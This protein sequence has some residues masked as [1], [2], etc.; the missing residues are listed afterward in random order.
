VSL[1]NKLEALEREGAPIRV[2][3]VGAGQMGRGFIAQVT[4]IPGMETVAV[5]DVDPP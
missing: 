3:L 5:A 1:R 4:G 2:G